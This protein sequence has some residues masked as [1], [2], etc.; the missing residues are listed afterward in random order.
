[1]KM[2]FKNT[3]EFDKEYKKLKKKFLSLDDDFL[4]FKKVLLKYPAGRGERHWNKLHDSDD[5]YIL[6]TRL[7]CRYL[8]KKTLRV[9]YLHNEVEEKIIFIEIYFKGNKES[10]DEKR[11][12]SFIG[13]K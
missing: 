5:S 3:K 4:F 8:K 13:K 6:K 12:K 2:L 7:M 9:I 11:W 1:M 10:E